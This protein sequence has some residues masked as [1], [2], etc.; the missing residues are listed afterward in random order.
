MPHAWRSSSSAVSPS[1]LSQWRRTASSSAASALRFPRSV[2]YCSSDSARARARQASPAGAS[3]SSSAASSA[4]GAS[5]S[6]PSA[7]TAAASWTRSISSAR[8]AH[9]H[10]ACEPSAASA[11]RPARTVRSA[12]SGF[13]SSRRRSAAS[14]DSRSRACDDRETSACASLS[15]SRSGTLPLGAA[16]ST[17]AAAAESSV[18]SAWSGLLVLDDAGLLARKPLA[19]K[20]RAARSA[21]HAGRMMRRSSATSAAF[22]AL[23]L[24]R[25]AR[26]GRA[27]AFAHEAFARAASTASKFASVPRKSSKPLFFG[28]APAFFGGIFAPTKA[29]AA[30]SVSS[31]RSCMASYVVTWTAT[32]ALEARAA[33]AHVTSLLEIVRRTASRSN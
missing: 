18:S 3:S 30:A 27:A 28:A 11:A 10:C 25:R 29:A 22:G 33:A 1:Q 8:R 12:M 7:L 20:P 13:S 21:A 5:S 16:D 19:R 9:F 23:S 24:S 15:R 17:A 31:R 26:R 4:A 2:Q 14:A 32:P 6:R